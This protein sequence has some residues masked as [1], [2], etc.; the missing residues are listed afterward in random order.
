M[1]FILY[2]QMLGMD[3][4]VAKSGTTARTPNGFFSCLWLFNSGVEF[5]ERA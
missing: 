2:I 1:T 4:G 5:K 3:K